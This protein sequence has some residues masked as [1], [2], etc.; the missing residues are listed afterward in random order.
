MLQSAK[1]FF[2]QL[3]QLQGLTD[4]HIPKLLTNPRI[5]YLRVEKT[6]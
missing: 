3:E 6:T 1:D 4:P 2:M 5:A